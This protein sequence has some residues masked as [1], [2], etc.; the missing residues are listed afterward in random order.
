MPPSPLLSTRPDVG[1]TPASDTPVRPG[2]VTA[3]GV[4]PRGAAPKVPPAGRPRDADR[5][6]R[7]R[8]PATARP[9]QRVR[10][11][12]SLFGPDIDRTAQQTCANVSHEGHVPLRRKVTHD[13]P[14]KASGGDHDRS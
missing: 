5:R 3:L 12:G 4:D 2:R 6:G 9:P 14:E 10:H 8:P 13:L 7:T 11:S 1:P